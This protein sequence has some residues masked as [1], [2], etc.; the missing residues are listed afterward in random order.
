[1][2]KKLDEIKT[3]GKQDTKVNEES[4]E[5]KKI[6]LPPDTEEMKLKRMIEAT[7]IK[8]TDGPKWEDIGG[9]DDVKKALKDA[10]INPYIHP[11][12]YEGKP[13][14]KGILLF[15]PPGNGK[16]FIAKACAKEAK[17]TFFNVNTPELVS[18]W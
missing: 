12:L 2:L 1:M 10:I 14:I 17:C 6:E 13:G 8:L 11:E 9:L 4:K 7:I 16:T 3:N 18:K 5:T 15:G